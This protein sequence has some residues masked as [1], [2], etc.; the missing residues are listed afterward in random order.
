VQTAASDDYTGIDIF[1]FDDNGVV[2]E[3]WDVLQVITDGS[4]NNN[5]L[6]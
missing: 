1:C 2:V 5:G 3:H 4:A 6:F